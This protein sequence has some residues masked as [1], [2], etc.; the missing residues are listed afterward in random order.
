MVME[1]ANSCSFSWR[2]YWLW[3]FPII[4]SL[5]FIVTIISVRTPGGF[6]SW[7]RA[8]SDGPQEQLW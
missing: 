1:A 5:K 4:N 6:L 8:Y 7:L 2:I 3:V